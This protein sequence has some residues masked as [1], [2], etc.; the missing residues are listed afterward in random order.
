MKIQCGA[1]VLTTS[2][3]AISVI[4]T[5]DLQRSV[6]GQQSPERIAAKCYMPVPFPLHPLLNLVVY[7]KEWDLLSCR[8]RIVVRDSCVSSMQMML[9]LA[10]LPDEGEKT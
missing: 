2:I 10:Q 1:D 5:P 8:L 9:M 4:L 3:P 7:S 6:K